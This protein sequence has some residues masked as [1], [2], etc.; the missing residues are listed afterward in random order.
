MNR[1][2][3]FNTV[4]KHL[5][6]QNARSEN[7]D[8]DPSSNT[9]MYRGTDGMK[10]AIGCLIPDEVYEPRMEKHGVGRLLDGFPQIGKLLGVEEPDDRYFLAELQE[11]HDVSL[12]GE[13]RADL[14]GFAHAH[15]LEMPA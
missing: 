2:D 14:V 11:I 5:L 10:C 6:A 12:P 15:N 4:A 8:A 1:Q 13:W 3:V 9:C 7:R